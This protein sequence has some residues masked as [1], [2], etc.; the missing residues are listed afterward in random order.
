MTSSFFAS[1]VVLSL[2]CSRAEAGVDPRFN[3]KTAQLPYSRASRPFENSGPAAGSEQQAQAARPQQNLVALGSVSSPSVQSGLQGANPSSVTGM[4]ALN[5]SDSCAT[6]DAIFG[7]GVFPFDNSTATTGTEGQS[8][9]ICYQFS[10]SA[11]DNDVWFVWTAPSTGTATWSLCNG[12]TMDSKIAVYAGSACPVSGTALACNDDSCAA[13]S[14]LNFQVTGGSTYMLQLGNFHGSSGSS[15]AFT[16]DLGGPATY[17]CDP[18]VA[19]VIACPCSNPPAGSGAGCNNSASTGGASITATGSHAL[20]NPTLV[21]TTANEKPTATTILLQGTTFLFAGSAFGQG[22]RCVGG[23]LKRLFVRTAVAGSI[24]VP[25]F[26]L[27]DPSIP[28]RSSALGDPITTGQPR[29]YMAYYRDPI[30]LGG[31]ATSA[32]FNGTNTAQVLW[33]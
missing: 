28:A 3:P 14:A 11:I 6:P 15:G 5:G 20:A 29:Y 18:G 32:T 8:E 24:S 13:Q 10:W 26:G 19:G 1:L 25:N 22:V 4:L 23:G 7:T 27:G 30:V 17:L 12:T 9:N 21:F 33:L 16:L 31:C 2:A